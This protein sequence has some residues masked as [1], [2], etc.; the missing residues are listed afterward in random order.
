MD[1]EKARVFLTVLQ[2]GS[3][4]AAAEPL[5]YTTSGISRSI[6]S[7]EDETGVALLIRDRKGVRPTKEAAMFIPIFER[8]VEQDRLFRETVGQIHGL[9]T[10]SI[11]IGISYSAYFRIMADKIKAFTN[12]YPGIEVRT[13]QG[14]SS[15]LLEALDSHQIDFAIM[16]KREGNYRFGK[17]LEDPMVACVSRQSPLAQ[18]EAFPIAKFAEEPMAVA[19]PDLETDYRRA[20]AQYDITPNIKYSTS[21]IFAAYCLVEAGL[22]VSLSNRL[23]VSRFDGDVALLQTDPPINLEIG[24]MCTDHG[25]MTVA[26]RKFLSFFPQ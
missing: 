6:A 26:A 16:T 2:K 4:T 13:I 9:E 7:L 25:A 15:E 5:G 12:A 22:G 21:D 14:I 19:Y 23:E 17:L 3:F 18:M 8:M 24:I 20:L 11:T 10:G 1:T